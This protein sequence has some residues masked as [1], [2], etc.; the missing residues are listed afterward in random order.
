MAIFGILGPMIIE[1]R[2]G[3]GQGVLVGAFVM[4]IV[5]VVAMVVV[6]VMIRAMQWALWK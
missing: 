3:E 5:M 1:L 2:R 6:A 4:M